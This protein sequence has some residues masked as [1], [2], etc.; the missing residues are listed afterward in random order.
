MTRKECIDALSEKTGIAKV[1]IETVL[2]E[3]NNMILD[4]LKKGEDVKIS[5]FGTFV[6]HTRKARAGR[7]P[8]TG[9]TVQV[10]ET[11][12]MKFKVSKEVKKDLNS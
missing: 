8:K 10:P 3:M 12:V 5:G 6:A 4:T 7:N 11:K 1:T 9:E 2:D